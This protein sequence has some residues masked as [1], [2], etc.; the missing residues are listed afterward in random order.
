MLSPSHGLSRLSDGDGAVVV[1]LVRG[2]L[3]YKPIETNEAI[4]S[5]VSGPPVAPRS[6]C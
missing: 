5:A 4:V 3:M 2:W 1:G 6:V